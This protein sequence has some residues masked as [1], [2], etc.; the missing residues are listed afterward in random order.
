MKVTKAVIWL[1][2]LSVFV[3]AGFVVVK[4]LQDEPTPEPLSFFDGNATDPAKTIQCPVEFNTF[5]VIADTTTNATTIKVGNF[6]A[7]EVVDIDAR[8]TAY[9]SPIQHRILWK[10]KRLPTQAELARRVT[11]YL[12]GAKVYRCENIRRINGKCVYVDL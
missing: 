5:E 3:L 9:T 7:K 1:L 10:G 6:P 8:F 4:N 12:T 2:T 11:P